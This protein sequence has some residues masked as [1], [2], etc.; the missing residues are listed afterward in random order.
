LKT[1]F[2]KTFDEGVVAHQKE[3]L[4]YVQEEAAS[5]MEEIPHQR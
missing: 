2:E 4:S 3:A 1:K 5:K